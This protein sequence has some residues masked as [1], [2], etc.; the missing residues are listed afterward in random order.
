[1]HPL[2][3]LEEST[4]VWELRRPFAGL[5]IESPANVFFFFVWCRILAPQKSFF[6]TYFI[7]WGTKCLQL[8]ASRLFNTDYT[9]M[10]YYFNICNM[11][12][13][14][15]LL[16]YA[17]KYVFW[18]EGYVTLIYLTTEPF[19]RFF[20]FSVYFNFGSENPVTFLDYVHIWFILCMIQ[21]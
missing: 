15:V 12:L 7:S 5:G 20:F 1:M 11:Q 17:E 19:S 16:K 10:P 13:S 14:N 9:S 21:L 4:N 3:I 2:F 6:V 18:I 8:T